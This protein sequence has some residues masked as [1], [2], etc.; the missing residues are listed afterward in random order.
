ME[1]LIK[2]L[3]LGTIVFMGSFISAQNSILF[4][5]D[6]AINPDNTVIIQNALDQTMFGYEVFDAVSEN[7]APN[8]SEMAPYSLVIWYTGTDG[9]ARFFWNA[10]DTDNTD[11]MFY[12]AEGGSL[13]VMG[14][15]FLFDRY[16]SSYDF[17]AGEFVY[18]YLGIDNYFGQS[19]VD[20]GGL[21]V[22]QLD[23]VA[24]QTVSTL[25]PILWSFATLWYADA[26]IPLANAQSIYNMGPDSYVL[27]G[28][29]SAVLYNTPTHNTLSFFFDPALM[30]TDENRETLF[31]DVIDYFLLLNGTENQEIPTQ[32]SV[33]PNPVVQGEAAWLQI[34]KNEFIGE[35]IRI[36]DASGRLMFSQEI[37]NAK[38]T[39]INLPANDMLPGVYFI[40]SETGMT[41]KFLVLGKK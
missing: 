26:C 40:I 24:G 13:W 17:S 27:S 11:L 30:D 9:V 16:G 21:G 19:Y 38:T 3:T 5:N 25:D 1:K 2:L 36:Y 37:T 31:T 18:D 28:Y 10:N 39:K 14:N 32:F 8:F 12:L 20:D 33:Y 29:S 22:P 35:N 34:N 4:V 41:A 7:R 6:N 23:L 15:D